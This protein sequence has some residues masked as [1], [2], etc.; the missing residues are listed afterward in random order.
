[1]RTA[2][3]GLQYL[4]ASR[5]GLLE[6]GTPSQAVRGVLCCHAGI[7]LRACETSTLFPKIRW[8]AFETWHKSWQIPSRSYCAAGGEG[9]PLTPAH[10]RPLPTRGWWR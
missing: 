8:V 9:E 3:S 7:M 1:M 5:L 10:A 6:L 4:C 2:K